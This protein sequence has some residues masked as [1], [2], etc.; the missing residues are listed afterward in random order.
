MIQL[1]EQNY[2]ISSQGPILAEDKEGP[3]GAGAVVGTVQLNLPRTAY[4]AS[5]KDERLLQAVQAGTVEAVKALQ[6]RQQAISDRVSEGVLPLLSWQSNGGSYY[7]QRR[8]QG[9][10]GL[11][12]LTEAVKYHTQNEIWEKSSIAFSWKIVEAVRRAIADVD[13]RDIRVR[14]GTHASSEASSRL[15]GIDAER[16]GF[17]TVVYQGSKKY[18]YYNDS[19]VIPITT[20][21][22]IATRASVEGELQRVF[23]GGSLLP[24]MIGPNMEKSALVQA[25]N[26]LVEAGVR[27]F[28][29]SSFYSRCR[30]CYKTR[31]GV[32]ARC[33]NCGFE[34]LTILGKLAGNLMPI[35]LMND[36]RKRDLDRIIPYDFSNL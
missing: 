7:D 2:S 22:P 30:R 8:A 36:A 1:S 14:V 17:S 3:K 29:F 11:L 32:R 23:D 28:T 13:A 10:I 26:Q 33:D 21:V 27:Y 5:G 31:V 19:P 16:F 4:E 9:E 15:A 34:H 12:G 24:L 20:K 18:P 25:S 6:L 35:D